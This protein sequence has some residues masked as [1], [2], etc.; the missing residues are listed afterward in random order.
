MDSMEH[1]HVPWVVLL[2][3]TASLWKESVSGSC[4]DQLT[5][6]TM[7]KSQE[8]SQMKVGPMSS[9]NSRRSSME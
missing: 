1:S 3:K 8:T 9:E 6:S 4:D 5:N 7:G 2:V